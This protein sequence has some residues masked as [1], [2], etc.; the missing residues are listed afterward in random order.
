MAE[1]V[2]RE[3]THIHSPAGHSGGL[4]HA[5]HS[6]RNSIMTIDS[7]QYYSCTYREMHHAQTNSKNPAM[8]R[9]EIRLRSYKLM[10]DHA[11][12]CFPCFSRDVITLRTNKLDTYDGRY[13]D[14]TPEIWDKVI[15]WLETAQVTRRTLP[16]G[17]PVPSEVDRHDSSSI[18][19]QF[20][21]IVLQNDRSIRSYDI[22]NGDTIRLRVIPLTK[23]PII[24]LYSPSD[25][26]VSVKL[27][28]IPEWSLWQIWRHFHLHQ[29][30][31]RNQ[32]PVDTFDP[33]SSNLDD[34]DSVVIP[35]GKVAVYLE[36]SLKALG[37]HTEAR[38]SF[39]TYW[40]PSFLKH[41]YIAL[42]FVPQAA[43]ERAASL[44]LTP[45]P[46][47]VTR[48]CMLFKGIR[49]EHLANW[50]NAQMQAERDVGWWVDVVGVDPVR[51][52]DVTLFRVLEWG[53][54]EV[55]D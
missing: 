4:E 39:I 43:Y 45:Q 14:I 16:D 52:G 7:A 10:L 17:Q 23:K 54:T 21:V 34:M 22:R 29:H 36:R 55:F 47:V 12:E 30:P 19:A 1:C 27:S 49:E 35:V 20:G 51:A 11:Y 40:L 24:Y 25:I 46:D 37:L 8:Y 26:D 48:V 6:A 38:T 41:E 5:Q 18:M 33:I 42:R 32:V 15:E 13:V 53:G 3:M 31:N 44:S 50:S 28:L 2:L 9:T